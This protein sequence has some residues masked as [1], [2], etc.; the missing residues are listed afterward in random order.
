MY[1]PYQIIREECHLVIA[2]YYLSWD[3]IWRAMT[4]V[5]RDK[6]SQITK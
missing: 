5:L 2:F 6:I 1:T 3:S 4:I